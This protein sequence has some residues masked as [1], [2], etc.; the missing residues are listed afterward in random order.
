M[1][2]DCKF[3]FRSTASLKDTADEWRGA[4]LGDVQRPDFSVTDC[5]RRLTKG[6]FL[7]SGQPKLRFYKD[8]DDALLAYVTHNPPILHCRYSVWSDADEGI[9][10]ARFILAHEL[11]HLTQHDYYPLGFSNEEKSIWPEGHSGEWQ[12]NNFGW[13][14][15]ISDE[16][17]ERYVVPSK[18]AIYCAVELWVAKQRLGRRLRTIGDPCPKCGDFAVMEAKELY[19]C[20]SCHHEYVA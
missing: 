11:G 3:N 1:V 14:F 2:R 4:L 7:K 5:V 12:A 19:L 20:D 15:L 9:P 13:Y 18:I 16:W 6:R 17:V 10:A 8:E